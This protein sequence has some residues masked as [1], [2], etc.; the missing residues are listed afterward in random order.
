MKFSRDRGVLVI[1]PGKDLPVSAGGKALGLRRIMEAGLPIPP[2]WVVLPEY[3]SEAL[4]ALARELETARITSLAVRSSSAGEDD[5]RHSFAGIHDTRLGIAPARLGQAVREV[6]QSVFSETALQ[7][8]ESMGL[9]PPAEPGAVVIQA[10][11][12]SRAAG[13]AFGMAGNE[14][15]VVIEAVE[16][17]GEAAVQG[18]V[19]PEKLRL[20]RKTGTWF[21]AERRAR[22]QPFKYVLEANEAVHSHVSDGE[23]GALVLSD[24]NAGEIADGVSALQKRFDQLL[25]IEWAIE[26][27]TVYFLQ[28]RPQTRS[29]SQEIPPGRNW[30]RIN[31]REVLPDI[32]S[33]MMRSILPLTLVAGFRRKIRKQGLPIGEDEP[34]FAFIYGRPVFEEDNLFLPA[35]LFGVPRRF[36]QALMGD[37]DEG[38]D[39]GFAAINWFK[40]WKHPGILIRT[41][42]IG[43]KTEKGVQA[44]IQDAQRFS[45]EIRSMD[46]QAAEDEELI[47]IIGQ[48]LEVQASEFAY[49][50]VNL[51]AV[52]GNAQYGAMTLIKKMP[53]PQALISRLAASG[54][55][56]IT[57]VQIDDLVDVALAIRGS[58]KGRQFL[59]EIRHEHEAAS[60]WQDNLPQELW[61]LV[62]QWLERYGH[63]GPYE[64]DMASPRYADDLRIL[65]QAM[66]PL[67]FDDQKPVSPGQSRAI[68]DKAGAEA[69]ALIDRHL[70][71]ITRRYFRVRFNQVKKMM[72]LREMLRSHGIIVLGAIRPIFLE[73]G[74]RLVERKK[75]TRLEDIWRLSFDEFG[76][77]LVDPV[78]KP[79]I[80]VKRELGRLRAWQRVE[81][82]NR[83]TSEEAQD[84]FNSTTGPDFS[85]NVLTG[86]GIS[87][88]VVEGKV[89][90]LRFPQEGARMESGSIL[91]TVA[92]DPG[93]TPLFARSIGV[94]TEIGGILSHAGI[95]AR[96]Y[97]LPCVS[98]VNGVTNRLKDGDIIQIDGTTGLIE[99][100][101]EA[102]DQGDFL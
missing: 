5:P 43:M 82:P 72:A 65:A 71:A 58:R 32:P 17:L 11:V 42:S 61:A 101:S 83:F 14:E 74:R 73:L 57:T 95:V 100:L 40:A 52:L 20:E 84:Y 30:T 50:A 4:D 89:C 49:H 25:D 37:C 90:V 28:A 78:F 62:S 63:R 55:G 1:E 91:V 22:W 98:N 2:A 53:Q 48:A 67:V 85:G 45:R 34:L 81:V 27:D 36:S 21:I 16:G 93:W 41:A 87:P 68:R 23:W 102:A 44:F 66:W 19:T 54:E 29:L 10:M 8:R 3:E 64:S 15:V 12:W 51:A 86:T 47:G 38:D 24:Q 79:D 94:V 88:G 97:G 59:Q 39:T 77:A 80:V 7:Y 60:Y 18:V 69:W 76:R 9:P 33:A 96:E 75:L 35:D 31:A 46:L 56:S 26:N 70:G 13:I 6:A 99:I 92:T